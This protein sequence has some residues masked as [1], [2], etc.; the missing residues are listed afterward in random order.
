VTDEDHAAHAD[1]EARVALGVAAHQHHHGD[2][3]VDEERAPQEHRM[4][5]DPLLK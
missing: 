4:M 1:E 3:E 2:G 5:I